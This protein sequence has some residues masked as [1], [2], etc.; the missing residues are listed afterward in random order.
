MQNRDK[1]AL[2]IS[3]THARWVCR[4]D[5]FDTG[6]RRVYSSPAIHP[7][8]C[9]ME[10]TLDARIDSSLEQNGISACMECHVRQFSRVDKQ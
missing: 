7:D 8:I 10:C 4:C 3:W 9:V 6:Q 5:I 1:C 2:S